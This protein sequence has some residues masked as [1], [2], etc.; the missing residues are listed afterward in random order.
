MTKIETR[1][2]QKY[3]DITIEIKEYSGRIF[4]YVNDKER[5]YVEVDL[6][7]KNIVKNYVG[8]DMKLSCKLEDGNEINV[9][10]RRK[11]LVFVS[12][13]IYVNNLQIGYVKDIYEKNSTN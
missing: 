9:M 3:K 5:D 8:R 13:T 6:F 11:M 1:Y 12:A 7:G 2:R 10:L 4:L